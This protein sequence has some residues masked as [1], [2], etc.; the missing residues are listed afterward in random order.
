MCSCLAFDFPSAQPRT[1]P[2][3]GHTRTAS[4]L[5][6]PG[7]L[8]SS[9]CGRSVPQWAESAGG[10][11]IMNECQAI[12]AGLRLQKEVTMVTKAERKSAGSKSPLSS[13]PFIPELC[14]ALRTLSSTVKCFKVKGTKEG[15]LNSRVCSLLHQ[16]PQTRLEWA[17]S[18]RNKDLHGTA[19]YY[20]K[21]GLP[22]KVLGGCSRATSI[23]VP[24]S[25]TCSAGWKCTLEYFRVLEQLS[26]DLLLTFTHKHTTAEK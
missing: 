9:A 13:L 26:R 23:A 17:E 6:R 12:T 20:G 1:T 21:R 7:L 4:R 11:L 8:T 14:P 24:R 16:H 5:Q 3:S 10:G 15:Q 22:L 2:P 25:R 19:E 18:G